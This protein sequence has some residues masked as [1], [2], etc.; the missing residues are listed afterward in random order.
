MSIMKATIVAAA[1]AVVAIPVA[2]NPGIA[3]ILPSASATTAVHSGR[4]RCAGLDGLHV[5][6]PLEQ[7]GAAMGLPHVEEGPSPQHLRGMV[8]IGDNTPGVSRREARM[9]VRLAFNQVCF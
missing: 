7:E 8:K 2:A 1:L 3:Q 6:L 5:A 4:M 9:G